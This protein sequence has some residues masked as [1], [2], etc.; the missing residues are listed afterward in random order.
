MNKKLDWTLSVIILIAYA[1]LWA[2]S[3]I[4]AYVEVPEAVI[5]AIGWI[6]MVVLCLMYVV[7]LYNA[8]CW[9]DNFILRIVF[10]ALALFLIASAIAIRVPSVYNYIFKNHSI[11]L[12]I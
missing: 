12:L 1:V 3:W 7:V 11:P 8:L 2:I 10:I 6:R 9:T 5:S 4:M